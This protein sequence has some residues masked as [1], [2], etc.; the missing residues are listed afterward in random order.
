MK[1]EAIRPGTMGRTHFAVVDGRESSYSQKPLTVDARPG[2]IYNV[3]LDVTGPPV[4]GPLQGEHRR[5]LDRQQAQGRVG[6]VMNER[7]ERG[8]ASGVQFAFTR[9]PDEKFE[10]GIW[11]KLQ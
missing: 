5:F 2:A 1:I 9:L 7:D 6:R 8:V 10:K 3:K 11:S 4:H